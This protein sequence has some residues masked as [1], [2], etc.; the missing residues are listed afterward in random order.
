MIANRTKGVSG[1]QILCGD[2]VRASASSEFRLE[3]IVTSIVSTLID[4]LLG[5]KLPELQPFVGI[6]R[7]H[8]G[9]GKTKLLRKSLR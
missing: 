4:T 7:S 3:S 1:P 6:G 8:L 5:K 2:R 9:H